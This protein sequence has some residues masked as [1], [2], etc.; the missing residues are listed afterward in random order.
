MVQKCEEVGVHIQYNK[1]FSRILEEN[2]YGVSFQFEDNEIAHTALLVGAD[3]MWSKVRTQLFPDSKA[4]YAKACGVNFIVDKEE[5]RLPRG[6]DTLIGNITTSHG[7]FFAMP[8][9]NDG[10]MISCSRQ[11]AFAER[12]KEGWKKLAENKDLLISNLTEGIQD[13]PDVVKSALEQIKKDSITIWPYHIVPRIETWFSSGK[14][15]VLLGDAAHTI[16][17]PGAQG[18]NQA[19]E[20]GY[21]LALVLSKVNASSNLEL[22][23]SKW[24]YARLQ[25]VDKV[26]Q[27]SVIMLNKRRSMIP[28]LEKQLFSKKAAERLEAACV[29]NEEFYRWLYLPTELEQDVQ[30]HFAPYDELL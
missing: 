29:L 2:E 17:P 16:P 6:M 19:F 8:Q 14:R 12:T 23:L 21:T 28:A 9:S 10:R 26:M 20:D 3:G 13:M 7:A 11:V 18:A 22:S 30:G 4:I 5:L 27:M 24:Y 15:V 25:R 1:K